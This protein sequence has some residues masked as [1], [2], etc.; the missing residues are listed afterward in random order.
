[1]SAPDT[2]AG[3]PIGVNTWVWVSPLTDAELE[4]LAPRVR[5]W[6]FDVIELPVENP[7]DWDPAR[8]AR[9]L[10]GLGLAATVTLVMGEGRE[11]VATDPATVDRTRDYLRRVV[12]AAATVGAPVIAGPAYASVGRTW[13]IAAAER[14][15]RYAELAD[16]LAPVV[17]HARAAGVRVAVEPLNRYETSL[18][19]TVDQALEALRGLPEDGC[20]LLLDVYHMNI[21]ETDIPAAIARAAGRIAH[22][23]VCAN[24]RGAPGADHLDWPAILRALDGAGYT[25]PLVIE[26]FTADNA[27][28]A[29]AASIW[30]P[31]AASQDAIAVD[32]LA[33]LRRLTG[34]ARTPARTG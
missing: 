4:R 33:H 32:G 21:E 25:G 16:G 18:L 2:P 8:A 31:L 22:V 6:G 12:D 23:Q 24:D 10:D 15:D 28:I 11:L 30:R 14:R 3:H 7:G 26:S 19:N 5:D 17:E 29:T 27:T 1:M 9:L 20:G 13:R 34:T